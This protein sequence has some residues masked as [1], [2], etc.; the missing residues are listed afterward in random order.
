MKNKLQVAL[1]LML[2][3]TATLLS[4]SSK[5]DNPAPSVASNNFT[6][7]GKNYE[8]KSGVIESDGNDGPGFHYPLLNLMTDGVVITSTQYAGTGNFIELGLCSDTPAINA[9]TYTFNGSGGKAYTFAR[10][11]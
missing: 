3:L 11:R 7:D 4:C 5:H 2:L 6:Y 8:I 1:L 10:A 9:G